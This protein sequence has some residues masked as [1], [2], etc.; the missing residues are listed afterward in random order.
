MKH[1]VLALWLAHSAAFA[2][3]PAQDPCKAEKARVKACSEAITA[4][5]VLVVEQD[6]AITR[7]KAQVSTLQDKLADAP[8]PGMPTW[9]IVGLSVLAG[10]AAGVIISR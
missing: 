9:A 4:C 7:L 6:E 3:D 8:A 1:L 2:A 5:N 10:A